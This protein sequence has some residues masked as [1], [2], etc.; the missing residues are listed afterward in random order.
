MKKFK[1][2][3]RVTT[4]CLLI[5][6]TIVAMLFVSY[7]FIG[8][9]AVTQFR[10]G[11]IYSDIESAESA[12]DYASQQAQTYKGEAAS[13]YQYQADGWD[14]EIERLNEERYAIMHSTDPIVAWAAKD[15]FELSMFWVSLIVMAVVVGAW[16]L[17]YNYLPEIVSAEEFILYAVMYAIFITLYYVFISAAKICKKFAVISHRNKTRTKRYYNNT[18]RVKRKTA[19]TQQKQQKKSSTDNVIDFDSSKRRL[20]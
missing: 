19:N 2:F 12:R 5:V 6:G 7:T 18:K 16:I 3:C 1:K 15:G 20:G 9:I 13:Y 10:L 17:L 11:M 8:K 14:E 4:R